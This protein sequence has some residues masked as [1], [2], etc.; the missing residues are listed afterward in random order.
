MSDEVFGRLTALPAREHPDLLA[1]PVAEALREYLPSALVAE[2]DPAF[3]DTEALCA[4]YGVPMEA[5]ANA[6][7]CGVSAPVS[8]PMRCA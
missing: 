6:V 5:S 7:W 1:A 8:T 4:E 3:A 2:I